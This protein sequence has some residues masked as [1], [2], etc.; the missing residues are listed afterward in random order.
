LASGVSVA[1]CWAAACSAAAQIEIAAVA[2]SSEHTIAPV[3]NFVIFTSKISMGL[4]R[5]ARGSQ[6]CREF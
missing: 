6:A 1:A 3:L 5:S 2:Q 4:A